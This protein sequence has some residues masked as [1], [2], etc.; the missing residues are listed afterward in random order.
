VR[1]Y[2]V[3]LDLAN[4][5]CVVL[6]DG[7]LAAEKAD[8]LR[9]AG[10]VVR[11]ISSHEYRRGDLAGARL[12]VDA[13]DDVAVNRESWEEAEAA[14]ILINVV[15]RPA[16][17]RFIAPAIVRRDPLLI[18]ISTSGESPFLASALRARLE[19]WLGREWGPFTALVGRVRR[20]LRERGVPV[21]EQTRIYRRL[22][23]SDIRDLLRAGRP[24]HARL[25]AA[26]LARNDGNRGGRVALVG[27]GPGDPELLTVR[28]RELL[29]GADFVL[30][31]ALVSQGTLAL[32]GPDTRLE[33]VGKR[34]RRVSTRQAEITARLI[35]LARLGHIVVRLKGG[36][37]FVFGRGGEELRDLVAAGVDVLVV[38]GVSAAIAAPSAAGIPL[39]MR[40]VASS[41]A[42]TKA[43]GDGSLAR[44]RQLASAAD[45]LVVLM[46]HDKL[47]LVASALAEVLGP[48]R[49]AAVIS[50]ATLPE[51][52]V[53]T[54]TTRDIAEL[55]LRAGLGPPATLV[56]GEVVA[57]AISNDL[58][59]VDS[60]GFG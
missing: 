58:R 30:H 14:G 12:V 55:A 31:D 6:G 57:Q 25:R 26:S 41:M 36:D 35:E 15:D 28:A 11:V 2:P 17:C 44:I 49:P 4:Q 22:L 53:V 37:P 51:Q 43:E 7:K 60:A 3:F 23:N 27:A 42:V 52:E 56:V 33:D 48:S 40:G 19:R 34:G 38:P 18:A 59:L 50:N 13:S 21:A 1:Y 54:G 32:C 20:E 47:K 39:T 8:G 29:A 46:V 24:E 10:A 45:T 16:Q 5:P 9:E